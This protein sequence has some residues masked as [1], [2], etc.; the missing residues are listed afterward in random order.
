MFYLGHDLGSEMQ[1][2]GVGHDVLSLIFYNYKRQII[3]I[4][5]ELLLEI[6]CTNVSPA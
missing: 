3:N 2:S 5:L 6:T 1:Y 4:Y